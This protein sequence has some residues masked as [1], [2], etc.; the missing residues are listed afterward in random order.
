M[1]KIDSGDYLFVKY[2]CTECLSVP[3]YLKCEWDS[4]FRLQQEFDCVGVA[5]RNSD[6]LYVLYNEFGETKVR[7]YSELV[8]LPYL[9][10]LV[11]QKN[12]EK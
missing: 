4:M 9:Q 7:L 11:I 3:D 6:G 10:G 12:L 1:S 8:G 2:D 5:Y